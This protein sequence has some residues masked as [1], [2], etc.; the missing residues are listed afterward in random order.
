MIS[1]FICVM[2]GEFFCTKCQKKL[3]KLKKIVDFVLSY[4]EFFGIMVTGV[5]CI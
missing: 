2:R 1:P 3:K 4:V 5:N